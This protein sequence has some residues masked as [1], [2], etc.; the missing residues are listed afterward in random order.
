MLL[1]VRAV[2]AE[3]FERV[4]RKTSAIEEVLENLHVTREQVETVLDFVAKSTQTPIE[5]LRA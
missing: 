1:G 2:I 3:S 4:H 5:T